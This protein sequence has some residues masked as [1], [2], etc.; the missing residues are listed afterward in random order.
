MGLFS[1]KQSEGLAKVLQPKKSGAP[2]D[3]P[4]PESIISDL[5]TLLRHDEIRPGEASLLH[6]VY[7]DLRD[8]K[9]MTE[10]TMS[11]GLTNTRDTKIYINAVQILFGVLEVTPEL[12]ESA[13][14]L[15]LRAR[16]WIADPS[17]AFQTKEYLKGFSTQTLTKPSMDLPF[18]DK[19][20]P[21]H[22]RDRKPLGTLRLPDSLLN[23]HK[24]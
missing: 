11:R 19:V 9:S 6:G 5:D 12:N 23:P 1:R 13:R 17:L 18:G 16:A 8:G 24:D 2:F 3:S 4:L 21:G 14:H 7:C 20:V 22:E 10:I 15:N